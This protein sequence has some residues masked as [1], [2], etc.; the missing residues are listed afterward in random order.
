MLCDRLL[1]THGS[2]AKRQCFLGL[3]LEMRFQT[4]KQDQLVIADHT[5]PRKSRAMYFSADCGEAELTL[6]V[7][8]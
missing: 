2:R 6:T 1:R 7:F 4:P 5:A 3:M 8:G